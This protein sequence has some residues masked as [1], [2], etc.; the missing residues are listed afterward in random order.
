MKIRVEGTAEVPVIEVPQP[1]PVP[2]PYQVPQP[3]P[4]PQPE[5][6]QGAEEEKKGAN[7][8]LLLVLLGGLV[9]LSRR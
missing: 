6:T 4:V 5:E 8:L 3:Y 1:Y 2:E 9:L 7:W